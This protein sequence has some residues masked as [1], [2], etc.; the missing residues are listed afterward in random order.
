MS[1]KELRKI[2]SKANAD[3]KNA[4]G[5]IVCKLMPLIF[6]REEMASSR[7]QGIKPSSTD[8]GSKKKPL[9]DRKLSAIKGRSA[10]LH[11]APFYNTMFFPKTLRTRLWFI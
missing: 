7:G 9:D 10:L 5:Y 3:K 2:L 1:L 8:K 4:H 6:T 11:E